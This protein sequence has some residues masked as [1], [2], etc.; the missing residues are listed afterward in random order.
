M[1][2]RFPSRVCSHEDS[3]A[4]LAKFSATRK[5]SVVSFGRSKKKKFV[6]QEDDWRC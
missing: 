4:A 3:V 1:K 6:D 5:K 2:S